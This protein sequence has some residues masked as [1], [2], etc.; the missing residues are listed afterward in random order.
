MGQCVALVEDDALVRMSLETALT[1]HTE[2]EIVGSVGTCAE[3]RQ[4]LA[5]RAPD[6]M[7]VDL[8]LPDGSGLELI[9]EI[10]RNAPAT[11]TLVITVFGDE[12]AVISAIRAGA[13]GYLLK[14][15]PPQQIAES[16]LMVLEGGSPISPAA[17]N[18]VL[19]R[20]KESS[21]APSAPAVSTTLTLTEKTVLQYI[22]KGFNYAEIAKAQRT[23][24]NTVAFHIKNIYQKLAVHSRSEAVFE[25]AA[26]GLI[27]IGHAP[28]TG[29]PN[30]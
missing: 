6:V 15:T 25:A 24:V 17:A 10:S 4:L 9:D 13:T 1:S 23:S 21:P 5:Q 30:D 7:L 20:L 26:L 27:S 8:G 28:K 22:A 3:A 14:N 12:H 2:L 16:V 29:L 19:K 18:F 11:R